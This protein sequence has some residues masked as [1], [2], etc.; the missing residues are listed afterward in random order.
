MLNL[1]QDFAKRF[2]FSFDLFC[3]AVRCKIQDNIKIDMK[4]MF[5]VLEHDSHLIYIYQNQ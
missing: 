4:C 3:K 1:Q 5:F 2:L